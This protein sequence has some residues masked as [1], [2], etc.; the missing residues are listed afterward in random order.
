MWAFV[1]V[2]GWKIMRF[3]LS[4]NKGSITRVVY[5]ITNPSMGKSPDRYHR[6]L[7]TLKQM[8]DNHKKKSPA[9]VIRNVGKTTRVLMISTSI[10]SDQKCTDSCSEGHPSPAPHAFSAAIYRP[11]CASLHQTPP[12]SKPMHTGGYNYNY[13]A[14]EIHLT[15]KACNSRS[16]LA[17]SSVSGMHIMSA[18]YRVQPAAV[19]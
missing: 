6:N 9:A 11:S 19:L 13:A 3:R 4:P 7:Y 1:C 5:I 10:G 18:L 15:L 17:L 12:A 8:C 16:S 14:L 2:A